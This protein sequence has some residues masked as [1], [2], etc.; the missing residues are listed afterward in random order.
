MST[1][2]VHPEEPAPNDSDGFGR[3]DAESLKLGYEVDKYDRTSVISVPLL[4]IVFFVLAFAATTWLFRYL[5]RW[6]VDD[7]DSH[8]MAKERN[9]VPLNERMGRIGRGKGE[10]DQPRLEPLR[11]RGGNERAITSPETGDNPPYLH[12]ED[13]RAEPGRT[14]E[15]FSKARVP[16]DKILAGADKALFPVQ[17]KQSGPLASVNWTTAANA[18]RGAEHALA[19]SPK[20]PVEPVPPKN[21]VPPPKMKENEPPKGPG[22][23]GKK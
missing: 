4:V 21:D 11:Q 18:G 8:P 15:L 2:N 20:L 22:E 13:V 14:P 7:S 5:P 6:V 19:V 9:E 3:P 23:G 1:S 12:P 10:V 17:E 16:L